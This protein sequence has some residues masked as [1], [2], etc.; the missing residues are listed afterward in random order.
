MQSDNEDRIHDALAKD[1]PNQRPIENRPSRGSSH[2]QTKTT[3][4][5]LAGLS[6]MPKS[7]ISCAVQLSYLL[8]F[9]NCPRKIASH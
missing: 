1:T 3:A 5:A 2:I 7:L 9:S 4:K 6:Q 8:V